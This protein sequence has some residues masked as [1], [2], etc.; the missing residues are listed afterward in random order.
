MGSLF[1]S[2]WFCPTGFQIQLLRTSE[3]EV[4]LH[5]YLHRQTDGR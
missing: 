1:S 5:L 2:W 3:R 4:L